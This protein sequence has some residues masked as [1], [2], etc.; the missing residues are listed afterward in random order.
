M[1]NSRRNE[2]RTLVRSEKLAQGRP[3]MSDYLIKVAARKV[4]A[5]DLK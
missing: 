4:E 3:T 5:R 2:Q 1:K